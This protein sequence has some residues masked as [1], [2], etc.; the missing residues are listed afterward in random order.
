MLQS[1]TWLVTGTAQNNPP[2]FLLRSSKAIVI[3]T[4]FYLDS[5]RY[6]LHKGAFADIRYSIILA[7]AR[8]R[9]ME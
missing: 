1:Y 2:V 4:R 5:L 7:S 9:P 3:A 8:V 6:P